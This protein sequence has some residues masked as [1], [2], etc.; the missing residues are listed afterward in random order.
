VLMAPFAPQH[1]D[2]LKQ[3]AGP[4]DD[5]RLAPVPGDVAALEMVLTNQRVFG[6]LRDIGGRSDVGLARFLPMGRLRDLLVG[7]I[8]TTG[9]LGLLNVLNIGIPPTPDAAG[10]ARSPVGGWR[11]QFDRFTVFSFQHDVLEVVAPQL[12][13]EKAPRPAQLRLRVG[14]VSHAGITPRLNDLGYGRTRETCLNNLR[15]MHALDQQL[16][17]PP[18]ACREAAEFLMDAKL[19]C[20]LGGQYVLRETPVGPPRWTS[21][22]LEKQQAAKGPLAAHAPEGYQS[23]PLNWFRGLD[24]EATMTEKTISAHADII[25]QMPVRRVDVQAGSGY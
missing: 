23:P 25:M 2:F 6:G 21:T 10:F 15:L 17:V 24:L 16:H 4:A 19:I 8:G 18:A 20:P 5:L 7:Y 22:M 12:R 3:W 9:E 11:R 14:D 13:F 1:F